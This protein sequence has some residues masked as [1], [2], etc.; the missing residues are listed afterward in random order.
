MNTSLPLVSIIIPS[1]NSKDYIAET[2]NSA[3]CQTYKP[4]E[5]IVVDD[6]STD[7]TCQLF[8]EFEANGIACY[9]IENAGASNA[10]NFGLK[11]ASGDYIQFLDADDILDKFKIAKQMELMIAS[12]A[13]VC[14]TPWIDFKKQIGDSQSQ[15]K[16]SHLNHNMKRSGI[17]LMISFGQDNWFIPTVSWLVDKR[18]IDLAGIW[19]VEMLINN[20]GEYFSRV[21]FWAKLVVCC[22]TP[23]A[24]YRL[25]PNSLSK[26]NSVP[27]IEAAFKSYQKIEK[28]L[29]PINNINLM[30]YPKRLYYKQYTFTKKKYPALAKRAAIHFDQI[31]AP[32][33]LSQQKKIL[34]IYWYSWTI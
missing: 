16:F 9:Q 12:K 26:L 13:D 3:L 34:E 20:D 29:A 30:S 25:T 5:I 8:A 10:R 24:Y 18:L 17:E 6:G 14:Y 28:L 1:Y 2:I 23:L 22:N 4:I 19:D 7:E 21:L 31:K 32:C 33:F 27:K 15:F 11:K